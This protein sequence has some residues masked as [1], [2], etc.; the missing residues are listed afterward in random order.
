MIA[1]HQP[2]PPMKIKTLVSAA[3]AKGFTLTELLVVI[4]MVGMLS[5]VCIGAMT[6]DNAQSRATVC[7][8]NVRQIVDASQTYAN[9][10]QGLLPSVS[11]SGENWPWDLPVGLVQ[12][13]LNVGLKT[14]NFYCPGTAPKFTDWQNFENPGTGNSLWNFSPSIHV[15]G[16]TMAFGGPFSALN[17]TNQNKTIQPEMI[18]INS[19]RPLKKAA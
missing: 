3:N 5:V 4:A 6:L 9:E 13:L 8:D 1:R 17:A 2:C 18:K 16:Y 14:N 7:A 19:M 10:N 15:V 11:T 12:S